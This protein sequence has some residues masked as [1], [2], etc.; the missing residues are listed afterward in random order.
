[1]ATSRW[2]VRMVTLKV[3]CTQAKT[4]PSSVLLKFCSVPCIAPPP[5]ATTIV[6]AADRHLAR[7]RR[8]SRARGVTSIAEQAGGKVEGHI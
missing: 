6:A 2:P 4:Y 3:A 1:M 7:C 8:P 5:P